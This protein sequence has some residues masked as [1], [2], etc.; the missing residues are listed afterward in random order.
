MTNMLPFPQEVTVESL[1][2]YLQSILTVTASLYQPTGQPKPD[3]NLNAESVSATLTGI[4]DKLIEAKQKQTNQLAVIQIESCINYV[5]DSLN[6]IQS[7]VF[8][9]TSDQIA[10]AVEAVKDIDPLMEGTDDLNLAKQIQAMQGTDIFGGG[11]NI[12]PEGMEAPA[13]VEVV[14]ET[15]VHTG[16]NLQ[17]TG[18][19]FDVLNALDSGLNTLQTEAEN[20]TADVEDT[21]PIT[22][23][24]NDVPGVV[25][26]GMSEATAGVTAEALVASAQANE[27]ADTTG[28]KYYIVVA[29]G[30]AKGMVVHTAHTIE[31]AEI[32]ITKLLKLNPLNS[33]KVFLGFNVGLSVDTSLTM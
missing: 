29:T 23:S 32:A 9:I 30:S 17:E 28:M 24:L 8:N 7:E 33:I 25:Q 13:P 11:T 22:E 1:K 6:K 27:L 12:V 5:D 19:D 31:E 3:A 26:S 16:T 10:T 2:D 4:K 15:T 18:K 14:D 21:A 20:T